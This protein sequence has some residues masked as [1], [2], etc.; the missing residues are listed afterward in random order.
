MVPW[1]RV[2][3]SSG[4]I[5]FPLGTEHFEQQRALLM[6]EGV[7]VKGRTV[8]IKNYGWQPDMSQILFELDN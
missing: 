8:S 3:R 6:D 2:L 5:A 1:Y 7:V 4:Q